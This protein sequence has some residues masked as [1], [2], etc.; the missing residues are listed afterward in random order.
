MMT[1][2]THCRTRRF[3]V[4]SARETELAGVD[5]VELAGRIGLTLP[6]MSMTVV[7]LVVPPPPACVSSITEPEKVGIKLFE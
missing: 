2:F 6:S 7:V 5:N 1:H 3:R 4:V